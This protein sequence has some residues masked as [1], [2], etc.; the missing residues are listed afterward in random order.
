MTAHPCL[1]GH[2]SKRR[3][4]GRCV[5]CRRIAAKKHYAK[6]RSTILAK[7][8]KWVKAHPDKV[9]D[10][11]AA[12]RKKNPGSSTEWARLNRARYKKSHKK[13]RDK[14]REKLRV[15]GQEY[16]KNNPVVCAAYRKR[17]RENNRDHAR[18]LVRNRRARIANSSGTH[19]TEDVKRIS[20]AQL[21]RCGYCHASFRT[22]TPC[23][24]HIIPL[25]KGGSNDRRNLQLLC[26]S[27]NSR[28]NNSDP[29]EYARRIGRLL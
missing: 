12:W 23:V 8:R 24:D 22:T 11:H 29:I 18:T 25:S 19:T 17:W 14:N 20:D 27:C 2:T 15:I 13:W 1:H 3:P 6:N 7:N 28:K 26:G 9:R 4:D 21:N 10:L 5:E 16:R